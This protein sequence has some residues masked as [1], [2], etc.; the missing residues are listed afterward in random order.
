M[1]REQGDFAGATALFKECVQFHRALEDREGVSIGLLGLSDVARDQ[2]DIPQIRKFAEESLALM[3]EL[4]VQWA[5]GFA[6][7][8][9]ALGAYLEDDLTQAAALASESVSLYRAQKADTK[10]AGVLVTQGRILRA[11]GELVAA[12]ET[13]T[14]ALRLAFVV[15][16]RLTVVTALEALAGVTIE[17]GEVA[18]TVHMLSAA[19]ILRAQMGTP[20]RPI[21]QTP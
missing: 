8:N 19:S 13:L 2:G 18:W 4:G 16:P 17:Q 21:D 15:G 7:N 10:L 11:Q 1:L 5:M 20:L 9:L 12:Q 14:E 6:L 3:R